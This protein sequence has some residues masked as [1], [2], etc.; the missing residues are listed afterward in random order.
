M[1]IEFINM[2][3]KQLYITQ[4]KY[5]KIQLKARTTNWEKTLASERR[6][7][8]KECFSGMMTNLSTVKK[9]KDMNKPKEKYTLLLS[10]L[11]MDSLGL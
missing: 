11:F 3:N 5:F 2:K 6:L 8:I 9:A 4:Q 10:C 7:L 1:I